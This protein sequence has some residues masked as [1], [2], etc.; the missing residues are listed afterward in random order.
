MITLLVKQKYNFFNTLLL[1]D[2]KD[3]FRRYKGVEVLIEMLKEHK[4]TAVAKAL[5]HVLSDNGKPL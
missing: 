5:T 3:A 1:A 4:G 2:N